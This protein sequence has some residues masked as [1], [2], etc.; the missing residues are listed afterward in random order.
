MELLMSSWRWYAEY[1]GEKV[2]WAMQHPWSTFPDDAGIPE[3]IYRQA[4]RAFH[5]A[6]LEYEVEPFPLD[7]EDSQDYW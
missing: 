5:F 2:G 1:Y 4:R 3:D 6:I 7:L